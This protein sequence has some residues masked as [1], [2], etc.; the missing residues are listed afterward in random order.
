MPSAGNGSQGFCMLGKFSTPEMYPQ[1]SA[2]I[3]SFFHLESHNKGLLGDA[4]AEVGFRE[5]CMV[6]KYFLKCF[7][8]KLSHLV[9]KN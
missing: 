1:G 9:W 7:E 4:T 6:Y 3:L 8:C 5:K 2:V